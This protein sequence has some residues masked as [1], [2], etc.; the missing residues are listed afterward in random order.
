M[1]LAFAGK[2]RSLQISTAAQLLTASWVASVAIWRWVDPAFWLGAMAPVDFLLAAAFYL[3]SWRR[4]FPV[5][6][7][8]L[9]GALV[10]YHL[11]A[12][13]IDSTPRWIGV[14]LNR[15]FEIALAYVFFCAVFRISQLSR[16]QKSAP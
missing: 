5:P 3:M 13:S 6:L 7:F 2:A 4:W 10:I 12:Y 16:R 9:H 1:V 8:V 15:A 11:Y 14:F